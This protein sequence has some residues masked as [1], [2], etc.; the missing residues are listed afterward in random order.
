MSKGKYIGNRQGLGFKGECSNSKIIFVKSDS[1]IS[2]AIISLVLKNKKLAASSVATENTAG[3]VATKHKSGM[4]LVNFRS[5]ASF[6][7]GSGVSITMKEK[8]VVTQTTMKSI[9]TTDS[10]RFRKS[11]ATGLK[12]TAH[13]H[14]FAKIVVTSQQPIV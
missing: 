4:S 7:L 9:A 13:F 11:V 14:S 8:L 5:G 2:S 6:G 12:P 10:H 3:S 1:M